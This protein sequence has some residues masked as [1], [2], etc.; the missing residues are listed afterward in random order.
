MSDVQRANIEALLAKT[1]DDHIHV[2]HVSEPIPQ[3]DRET[4]RFTVI[5]EI[6]R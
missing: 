4:V 5:F 6:E 3:A 1:L 2:I